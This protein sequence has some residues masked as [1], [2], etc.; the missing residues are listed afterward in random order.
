MHFSSI[1]L[2]SAGVQD[3]IED[4]PTHCNVSI[5]CCWGFSTVCA[6]ALQLHHANVAVFLQAGHLSA[7]KPLADRGLQESG[8]GG[9]EAAQR[10][11]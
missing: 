11:I 9:G 7:G 1:L 2:R 4:H 3:V 5:I 6:L 8:A 10:A